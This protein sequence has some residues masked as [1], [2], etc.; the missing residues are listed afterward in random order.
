MV[1]VVGIFGKYVSVLLALLILGSGISLGGPAQV[2]R[3]GFIGPLSGPSAP[4]GLAARN[5]FDLAIREANALR[6]FPYRVEGIALDDASDPATGR[7]AAIKIASDA[8]VIA[9]IGHWNSPVAFAT[10]EV[11]HQ[12][13]M[14][15]IIWCAIHPD[16]TRQG[17]IE[18]VRMCPTL[19]VETNAGVSWILKNLRLK[20]WS[21]VHDTT[22]YGLSTRDSFVGTL[23]GFGGRVV[24]VDGI[25][26]GDRDFSAL[27]SRLKNL[28]PEG[29]YF[30][31][32]VTEAALFRVQMVRAGLEAVFFGI[33]GI[34][35]DRFIEI[36]G[37]AAEGTV[38]ST[39]GVPI[40]KRPGG[41]RFI[42]AYRRSGYREPLGPY[43]E[44]AYDGTNV[45]LDALR[46]VGPDRKRMIQAI[47]EGKYRGVVGD[48]G[49]DREGQSTVRDTAIYV[50][51]NGKWVLWE[52]SDYSK[53]KRQLVKKR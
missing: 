10:I 43:A 1:R 11:F 49:F 4:Q 39:A 21:V 44:F 50:V 19:E 27:I 33:G 5:A 23:R 48:F 12:F 53:G 37:N 13:G 52:M 31:G 29:V 41:L 9:G 2:V 3:I 40:E 25:N 36:A 26:V 22:T 6:N 42:E 17:Y 47:R 32:L 7:A 15:F 8:T 30:G 38:V 18:I 34:F 20:N 46:R 28:E 16:L 14:P 45:I 24:S 51:E 35:Y